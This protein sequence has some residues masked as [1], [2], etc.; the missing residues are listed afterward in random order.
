MPEDL[1]ELRELVAGKLVPVTRDY[2]GCTDLELL[3]D[4]DSE[5][6]ILV[7]QR[8]QSRGHFDR[9]LDWRRERGDL[10]RLAE[11]LERPPTFRFFAEAAA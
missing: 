10:P 1:D 3:T 6:S 5:T 7:L 11:L 4:L 9:Y 2:D 8:W